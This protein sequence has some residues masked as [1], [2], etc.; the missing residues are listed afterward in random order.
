MKKSVTVFWMFA[1]MSFVMNDELIIGERNSSQIQ[2][3]DP[4][5]IIFDS[6][7]VKKLF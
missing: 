7:L 6:A 5:G 3:G 1:P 4:F 2:K